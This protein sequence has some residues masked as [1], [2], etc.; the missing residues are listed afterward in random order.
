VNKMSE[1]TCNTCE[2]EYDDMRSHR[3]H[4]K[5]DWHR[6]NL[7]RRQ[8]EL[9][10]VPYDAFEKRKRAVLEK[11]RK[12][13]ERDEE[14]KS[15]RLRCEVCRKD[16][17]TRNAEKQHYRS[18]KHREA[19]KRA[20]RRRN[21]SKTAEEPSATAKTKSAAPPVFE[22]RKILPTDCLFCTQK[23]KSLEQNLHHMNEKHEFVLPEADSICNANGLVEYL[24]EKVGVGHLCLWCQRGFSS[25]PA[26]RAHMIDRGHCRIPFEV[27]YDLEEYFEFY[28]YGPLR[29]DSSDAAHAW[30]AAVEA[31]SSST[32]S[33]FSSSSKYKPSEWGR[34]LE[35]DENEELVLHDGRRVGNRKYKHIYKQNFAPEDDRPEVLANRKMLLERVVGPEA[36]KMM[37]LATRGEIRAS[38]SVALSLHHARDRRAAKMAAQRAVDIKKRDFDQRRLNVGIQ[39]N[40][41]NVSK[42][43][44]RRGVFVSWKT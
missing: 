41:V 6:Y 37:M 10:P 38:R 9:A 36:A 20:E 25:I 12:E 29:A 3:D 11:R 14:E 1:F 2:V 28:K 43:P 26:V 22:P 8:V 5:S 33:S 32:T 30:H 15:Q 7:R 44:H 19:I 23:S 39:M 27:K 18:K 35:I 17:A 34:I 16:F 31:C 4:Y 42:I 13:E 21:K 40:K 24:G